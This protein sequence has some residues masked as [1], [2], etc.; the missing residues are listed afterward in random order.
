MFFRYVIQHKGLPSCHSDKGFACQCMRCRRCGFN[1]SIRKIPWRRKQQPTPVFL[2]R[3]SHGQ[4]SLAGLQRVG[5]N[6]ACN[7]TKLQAALVKVEITKYKLPSSP[8]LQENL[9]AAGEHGVKSMDPTRVRPRAV[10][11]CTAFLMFTDQ[12]RY[13]LLMFHHEQLPSDSLLILFWWKIN[14]NIFM[15]VSWTSSLIETITH[16]QQ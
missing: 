14:D 9:G 13:L 6:W 12:E 16:P 5:H 10:S 3:E 15:S 11:I 2:L 4:R 8:P 1:P 7:K